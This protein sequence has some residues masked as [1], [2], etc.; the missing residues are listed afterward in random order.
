[1]R[2]LHIAI[3]RKCTVGNLIHA[4]AELWRTRSAEEMIDQISICYARR[5]N[6]LPRKCH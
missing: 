6:R 1:M 3:R 5:R 2:V 4:L